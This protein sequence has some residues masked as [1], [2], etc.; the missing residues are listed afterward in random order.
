[1]IEKFPIIGE[2]YITIQYRSGMSTDAGFTHT[3]NKD[4]PKQEDFDLVERT[5]KVVKVG[6]QVEQSERATTYILH[7]TSNIEILNSIKNV[8]EKTRFTNSSSLSGSY[9]KP[10]QAIQNI[11]NKSFAGYNDLIRSSESSLP[12]PKLFSRDMRPVS[13]EH[14]TCKNTLPYVPPG[15]EPFEAIKYLLDECVHV[16]H[17][18]PNP[19]N[20]EYIFFETKR[21][22]HLTTI[23]ELKNPDY[24]QVRS[25]VVGD[26]AS[27]NDKVQKF[28]STMLKL[29]K[30]DITVEKGL[31]SHPGDPGKNEIIIDYEFIQSID[32]F[33][34]FENGLY[35]NR[36]AA[37]DL[38]T[39][40]YDSRATY[41]YKDESKL[42]SISRK[43]SDKNPKRL[44]SNNSEFFT[45]DI[46]STNTRYFVSDLTTNSLNKTI[47]SNFT[48]QDI[49]YIGGIKNNDVSR[50]I[51]TPYFLVAYANAY[52][53][54]LRESI[55]DSRLLHPRMK[56]EALNM[57][58]MSAAALDN[59][60]LR[61]TVPGNSSI[62]VGE[63]MQV[64]IPQKGLEN[65]QIGYT[66]KYNEFIRTA[67]M[68][69]TKV[70]HT[71]NLKKSFYGTIIDLSLDHLQ[72]DV[73]ENSLNKAE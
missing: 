26:M 41:Y 66:N 56:Q 46:S 62:T 54:K 70:R 49:N 5:F 11:F 17:D 4:F 65:T 3:P 72:K 8:E 64:Y 2:E 16:E 51:D 50:Y 28:A 73:T 53:A 20:S 39:K 22:F 13:E 12:P 67:P 9:L 55:F 48:A 21:G 24:R 45:D 23:S 40:R 27:E 30:E 19:N 43:Y 33:K 36:V 15:V 35:K 52:T 60:Q 1:M 57:K 47:D 7:C 59:I 68:L 29:Q 58:V 69:I 63:L 31:T 61:V 18:S 10:T 37:V 34:N 25:Y 6:Q 42:S 71:Y 44:I 32:T 14:R 38:L